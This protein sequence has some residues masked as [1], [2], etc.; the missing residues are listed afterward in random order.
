VGNAI[1]RW[2]V[3]NKN[4]VNFRSSSSTVGNNVIK[5]L[6][7][8]AHVWMYESQY[9]EAN[10]VWTRV[11]VDGQ[12]GYIM[13]EYVDMMTQAQSDGYQATL[14]SP[15]P[16]RSPA[17]NVTPTPTP[18]P[19]PVPGQYSGYALTTKQVALRTDA[20][21]T[22]QSILATL[23]QNTLVTVL[24]QVYQGTVPWSL[25]ETLDGIMGYV[26]DDSLRRINQEEA[27][28]YIDQYNAAHPTASPTP[29]PTPSPAPT[30]QSGYAATLGD[31]VPVR[32]QADP[33]SM[34]VNMLAKNTVVY[35]S[36]QEYLDGTAWHIVQYNGQWGYI[37]ADQLRWLSQQ[38]T[39]TY[40]NNLNKPTP[41]PASTLPPLD[42][43][44]ASSYGYVTNTNG[45]VNFRSAPGGSVISTLNKYAFAL[46]LG[47]TQSGGKTWYKVN[48]AGREGYISGDFFHVLSLAELEEFLQ[49]PEYAQGAVD[50]TGNNSNNSGNNNNE[51]PTSPEDLNVGTWTNPNTG[52]NAT[53]EPFDPYTTPEPMPTPTA[54]PTPEPLATFEPLPTEPPVQ[55][56]SD[57]PS[58]IWL[59]LGVALLGGFGGLY[60]YALHKS[61]QR[62]A[63]ARAAQRR[64]AMQQNPNSGARP[65]ARATNAPMFTHASGTQ[66]RP[67]TP[68]A[69]AQRPQTPGSTSPNSQRPAVT[70]PPAQPGAAPTAR[71]GQQSNAFT[72]SATGAQPG[73]QTPASIKPEAQGITAAPDGQT[74]VTQHDSAL[75]NT[76]RQPRTVRHTGNS[77]AGK[78]T[79]T[80]TNENL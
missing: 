80:D 11:R 68:P 54:S 10:E 63:A 38:E 75:N 48:Q 34:L 19:T 22:D 56:Q 7:Q 41:T 24:N 61:N 44:S 39:Q 21:N 47:S 43:N 20:N 26:P 6:S 70:R 27:K 60:A 8:G 28:F 2:G 62:K 65:Y 36:G 29:T 45:K 13:T 25:T 18:T 4:T 64:A 77:P 40:L 42:Q 53:Y 1:D 12:D 78:S 16:T 74:G 14:P 46:V 57:S 58:F 66:A 15:M 67:G 51:P 76:T 5:K 37:R 55:T 52:L 35:V 50:N 71:P 79:P 32:G 30:Q 73:T 72:R 3:I 33:N 59:G 49:S 31:N 9:N 23:P 17:P 69:G